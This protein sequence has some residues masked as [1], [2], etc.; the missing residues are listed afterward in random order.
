MDT[1][2]INQHLEWMKSIESE[3]RYIE[4][5]SEEFDAFF[6][7]AGEISGEV[8][9]TAIGGWVAGSVLAAIFNKAGSKIDEQLG[10]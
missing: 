3:Y 5:E 6:E 8:I 7:V 1:E 9:G 10:L 4:Q 2:I